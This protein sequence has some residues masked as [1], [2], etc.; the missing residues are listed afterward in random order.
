MLRFLKFLRR[1][2]FRWLAIALATALVIP[3]LVLGIPTHPSLNPQAWAQDNPETAQEETFMPPDIEAIIERGELHVAVLGKDN[4]PFFQKDS[5]ETPCTTDPQRADELIKMDGETFCG[6]DIELGKAIADTLG[7]SVRYDRSAATF[8]DVVERVFEHKDDLA[9]S[10]ISR[11]M[12]RVK[13][14]SFSKP[15]VNMSQGLLVNRLELTEQ[16]KGRQIAEIFRDLEGKVGVIEDSSYV[17]FTE[18][19]FPDA[20]VKE[21][22]SWEDVIEAAREGKILAAYRDELE[23]KKI[24][25]TYPDTALNFQ[26]IALSDTND[27]IAA[28]IPW[29]SMHLKELVDQYLENNS[30]DYTADELLEKYEYMFVTESTTEQE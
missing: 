1:T 12:A 18:Q 17:G 11:T 8:N 23:V 5:P 29:D 30:V 7:V 20:E 4:Q 21:Y 16:A 9:F 2:R 13:K 27:A 6:L 25:R 24:I 28:V 26:T 15:Y 19:K 3:I 10:K 14:V 22:P